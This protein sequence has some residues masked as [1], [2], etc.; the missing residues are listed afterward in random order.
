MPVIAMN[1]EMASLGKDV[2][3]ALASEF[4]LEVAK[5]EVV[6]HVAGHIPMPSSL[7]RRVIEGKAGFITRMT[8]DGKGVSNYVSEAV[9]ELATKGN[10]VIR[11]WGATYLLREIPHIPCIRVCAPMEQRIEWLKKRLNTDDED[12]CREELE[13][14]DAAHINNMQARFGV[15]WGDP[16]LY[17]VVL[18]TARLSVDACVAQVKALLARPE[19]KETP[20]SIQKV[21]DLSLAAHVRAAL[22]QDFETASVN[23]MIVACQGA[24][25]LKGMVADDSEIKGSERVAKSVSG[26][27]SVAMD[28]KVIGGRR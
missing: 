11:G 25:L 17:D 1:Q 4:K 16:M 2:A 5:N 22:R 13:R 18:N 23:V 24:V 7:V 21:R 26:V 14:S 6:D 20:E 28:L 19:F 15:T 9:F 8:T 12:L 3:E 10:V 27:K